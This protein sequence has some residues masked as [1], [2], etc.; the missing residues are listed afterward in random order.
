MFGGK[1]AAEEKRGGHQGFGYGFRRR[2]RI[3][4]RMKVLTPLPVNVT[5][6][7]KL[8]GVKKVAAIQGLGVSGVGL[9]S[10]GIN[11]FAAVPI[12]EILK[13]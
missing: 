12:S 9:V 7:G 4:I 10:L 13:H 1:N 11:A 2:K 8:S 3:R 5:K 6:W